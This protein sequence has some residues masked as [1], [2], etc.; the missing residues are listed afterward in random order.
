MRGIL[1]DP[2]ECTVTDVEVGG[3]HADDSAEL[4][5]SIYTL[6]SHATVKVGNFDVCGPAHL[7]GRDV[8]Y[9]DDDGLQHAP[10]RWFVHRGYHQPLAGKGLILGA[11]SAGN[12]RPAKTPL[13]QVRADVRFLAV[14]GR[15]LI[16]TTTPLK[17]QS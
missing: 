6:L 13:E 4:L 1:I 14:D 9:V 16:E 11:D 17:L 15:N 3:S 2:F 12:T 8:L 10:P 5:Q 7:T